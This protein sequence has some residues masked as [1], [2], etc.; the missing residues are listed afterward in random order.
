MKWSE[1]IQMIFERAEATDSFAYD[2]DIRCMYLKLMEALDTKD[3]ALTK[4]LVERLGF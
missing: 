3:V 4:K 2:I 1:R